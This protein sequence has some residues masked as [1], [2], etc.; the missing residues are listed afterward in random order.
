M[1]V[2][3]RVLSIETAHLIRQNSRMWLFR[4]VGSAWEKSE[5]QR[6]I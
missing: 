3:L 6:S 5:T 2:N 1:H 4:E